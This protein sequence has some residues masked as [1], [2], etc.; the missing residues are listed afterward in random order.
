MDC[1]LLPVN[2][3][4]CACCISIFLLLFLK[5][6]L[7]SSSL[8][9]FISKDLG[10]FGREEE[11]SAFSVRFLAI[12]G[13]SKE[14][15]DRGPEVCWNREHSGTR[16]RGQPKQQHGTPDRDVSPLVVVIGGL[17]QQPHVFH[18][19]TWAH[20]A[21]PTFSLLIRQDFCLFA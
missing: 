21:L 5:E 2:L 18:A 17:F 8:F 19:L 3:F 1:I 9:P 4:G 15:D 6:V 13:A 12:C 10:E 11:S 7:L 16:N 14:K 20:A